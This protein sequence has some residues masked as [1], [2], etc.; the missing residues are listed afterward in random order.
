MNYGYV[1][2]NQVVDGPRRLPSSWRNISGLD[3]MSQDALKDIGWL[4]WNRIY[5]PGEIQVKATITIG[6]DLITETIEQRPLNDQEIAE[7]EAARIESIDEQRRAAYVSES[8]PV[9]FRW[10]RGEATQQDWLDKIAEI[11]ARYPK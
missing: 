2:N 5:T 1:E 3:K 10:Q 11:K 8:D 6:P 7:R 9:F 4:P